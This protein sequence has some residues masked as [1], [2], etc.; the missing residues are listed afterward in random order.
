VRWSR[1]IRLV[2]RVER[3]GLLFRLEHRVTN[4]D[5]VPDGYRAM[6]AR[7]ALKVMIE[8]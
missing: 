2:H 8:V 4:I 1:Q 5:G 6:N 7:K 3:R